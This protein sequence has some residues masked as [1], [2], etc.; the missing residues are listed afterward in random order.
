MDSEPIANLENQTELKRIN[1]L[2]DKNKEE[3]GNF[4]LVPVGDAGYILQ[5]ERQKPMAGNDWVF[6]DYD[7]T[8][9]ATPEVKDR[10]LD[11]YKAYLK[12]SGIQMTE[13]QTAKVVDMTDKFSRWEEKEGEGKLYHANTHMTALEWATNTVKN[14]QESVDEAIVNLQA[15]L[16]RIKSQLTQEQKPHDTDPFYFRS[17]DKKLVLQG[18]GKMWSK[19]VEDIFMQTMI[20]PPQYS[21]TL[22]AAKDKE[23]PVTSIHRTNL[24]IFTYGDPYYQLLKVYELMKK[25][26]DFPVSQIWLTRKPKGEFIVEAVK[27]G[28][29][30][31]FEQDYIPPELE[32]SP[33]E[34]IAYGSGYVLGQTPHVLVMM[35]DNP[36]ELSS[37][38]S[39]NEYLKK[40][41]RS[42][43]VTVRS[44]RY[45]TKEQNREWSVS[46]K[47]GELDFTTQYFS[48]IDIQN[49]ILVNRYLTTRSNLGDQHE[50]TIRLKNQL[51]TRGVSEI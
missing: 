19:D 11:L 25:H 18:V 49:T 35:D 17:K 31:K 32:D 34:G 14:N 27:E 10:R 48:P 37:I 26:P 46:T 16:D 9:V 4:E 43:F 21:E 3:L 51:K 28:S 45:G 30:G 47:Y 8:L 12:K 40:N 39:A 29:T 15:S 6:F 42:E 20:N 24:G 7:D 38:L 5:A 44:R 41:T 2:V 22:E 33:G 13:E 36:K 23:Q 50:N 1:I